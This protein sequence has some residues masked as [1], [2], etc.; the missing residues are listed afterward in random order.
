MLGGRCDGIV[1][2][3]PAALCAVSAG[4]ATAAAV[5][6]SRLLSVDPLRIRTAAILRG[7]GSTRTAALRLPPLQDLSLP[8]RHPRALLPGLLAEDAYLSSA[9]HCGRVDL[10]MK[11]R[12][13]GSDAVS[14]RTG[15]AI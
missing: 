12:E 10:E 13:A 3:G 1:P 8:G 11:R 5:N 14:P 6:V 4:S 2:P 9:R 7:T 15:A